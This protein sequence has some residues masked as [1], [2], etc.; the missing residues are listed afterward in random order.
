MKKTIF[1]LL[2][3]LCAVSPAG[4][5]IAD[6]VDVGLA[7]GTMEAVGRYQA[8]V[9]LEYVTACAMEAQTRDGLTINTKNTCADLLPYSDD[10]A[11]L[12]AS[13]FKLSGGSSGS[14][15]FSITTPTI[16]SDAVRKELLSQNHR[17]MTIKAE[18]KKIKFTI[19][20]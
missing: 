11:G 8:N 16:D 18:G 5:Q 14:S 6:V 9:I 7:P 17:I 12:D 4:A 2:L 13:K 3:C 19:K 20:R 15:T 1:G 10:P